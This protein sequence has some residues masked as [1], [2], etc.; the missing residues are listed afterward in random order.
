MSHSA[1][2]HDAFKW[3]WAAI[4]FFPD[5]LCLVPQGRS[6]RKSK[7]R[8]KPW[9]CPHLADSYYAGYLWNNMDNAI[10]DDLVEYWTSITSLPPPSLSGDVSLQ[11]GPSG[12]LLASISLVNSKKSMSTFEPERAL[13]SLHLVRMSSNDQ[14]DHYIRCWVPGLHLLCSLLSLHFRDLEMMMMMIVIVMMLIM[15]MTSETSRSFSRSLLQPTKT[16]TH[17]VPPFPAELESG[18]TFLQKLKV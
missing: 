5:P 7:T 1:Y 17:S 8:F 6:P 13:V 14:I 16:R 10:D 4:R 3:L 12:F 2:K 9:L 11:V 18:K 15:I